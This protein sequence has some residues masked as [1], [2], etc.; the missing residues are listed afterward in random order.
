MLQQTF[1]QKFMLMVF[2]GFVAAGMLWVFR[3]IVAQSFWE[4]GAG[5]KE[6]LYDKGSEKKK[7]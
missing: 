2:A 5:W 6:S 1:F 3:N 4:T 7:R